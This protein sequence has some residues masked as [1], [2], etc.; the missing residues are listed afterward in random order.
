[1]C[2]GRVNPTEADLLTQ[3]TLLSTKND[4]KSQKVFEV[5]TLGGFF[6][7]KKEANKAKE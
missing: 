7:Y 6:Y 5:K 3:P 4:G 2:E 1:V